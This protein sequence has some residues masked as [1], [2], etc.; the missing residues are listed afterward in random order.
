VLPFT[1]LSSGADDSYFADGLTEEIINALSALPDL[2]VT[3]RTSAFYFKGKDVPIPEIAAALGVAHIVEG[4]VR[5]SGDKVRITAQLIRASDGFHLWSQTYD[6]S[7]GDD[8]AVQTRI[9]ESVAS[10]LGVLLDER[11][12]ATMEDIGVRDVEAFVAY[13]RGAELFNRAHNEGA[14]AGA[15]GA[16]QHRVRGG[17]RA[18]ARLRGRLVPACGLLRALSNR[19]GAWPRVPVCF[20]QRG[21]ASTPRPGG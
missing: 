13:Q 5:R 10:A 15:A 2:L 6:H 14:D 20:W 19:R 12:R 1:A 4:S 18:Q 3:A 7:L 16:R 9:A 21:S 8:F 17:D 11:K